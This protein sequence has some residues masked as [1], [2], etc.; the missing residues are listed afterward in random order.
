MKAK[1]ELPSKKKMEINNEVMK[2]LKKAKTS[3]K[4]RKEARLKYKKQ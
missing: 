3:L 4:Q 2:V 1:Q